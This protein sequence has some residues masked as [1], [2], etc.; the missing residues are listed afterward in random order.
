MVSLEA[1]GSIDLSVLSPSELVRTE[2]KLARDEEI[3]LQNVETEFA[4]VDDSHANDLKQSMAQERGQISPIVVRAR[5]M[6]GG[7]SPLRCN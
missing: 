7:A 3:L 4:I 1:R 2:E 5:L 6:R